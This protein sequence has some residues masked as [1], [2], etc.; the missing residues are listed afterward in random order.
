MSF[1]LYCLLCGWYRQTFL[2]IAGGVLCLCV[3]GDGRLLGVWSCSLGCCCSGPS[4]PLPALWCTQVQW[5]ESF[6]P[7]DCLVWASVLWNLSYKLYLR[8][9]I[10]SELYIENC[11]IYCELKVLIF[12]NCRAWQR[13][14][15]K[16]NK[17]P[18]FQNERDRLW[19]FHIVGLEHAEQRHYDY[20]LML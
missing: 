7:A 19:Q 15:A 8:C 18:V 6:F 16:K 2:G 14:R 11:S 4:L 3:D 20:D 1:F 9:Q 10:K 5:G 12:H 17:D 13:R